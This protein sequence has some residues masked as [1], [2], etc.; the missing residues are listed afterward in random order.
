[1]S[2]MAEYVYDMYMKRMEEIKD[3]LPVQG[4]LQMYAHLPQEIEEDV[5]ATQETEAAT[6]HAI[7]N[8]E[9]EEPPAKRPNKETKK[10]V[11]TA[12]KF[13]P[14][15]IVNEINIEDAME[16]EQEQKAQAETTAAAAS[17]ETEEIVT[18]TETDAAEA[19]VTAE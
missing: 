16:Q 6:E 5:H 2:Q 3:K 7:P 12:A 1:M 13:T 15:P 17:I 11:K 18:P 9:I 10:P 4:D 8:V 14:T 19:S